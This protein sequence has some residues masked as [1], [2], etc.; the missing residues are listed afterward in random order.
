[1]IDINDIFKNYKDNI[2]YREFNGSYIIAVPFFFPNSS[3]SIAIKISFDEL[4]RPILSDCHTTLD[5]L[6]ETG[7]DVNAYR[8]KLEKIMHKY[9]LDMEDRAFKLAVPTTQPYYL[10]K[11]LGFFIQALSLIAGID[12]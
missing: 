3:D 7:I 12:I 5:Y 9:D 11:Y 2:S 8:Q 10:T 6:D 4:D 1:M